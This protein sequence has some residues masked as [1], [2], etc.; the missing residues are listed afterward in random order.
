MMTLNLTLTNEEIQ[1]I[2]KS[3][4]YKKADDAFRNSVL[5]AAD[6]PRDAAAL[7]FQTWRKLVGPLEAHAKKLAEP[8]ARRR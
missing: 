7:A 4:A 3:A 1:A 2:T 8:E 5:I 6:D